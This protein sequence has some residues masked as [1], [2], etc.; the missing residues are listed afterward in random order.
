M[1]QKSYAATATNEPLGDAGQYNIATLVVQITGTFTGNLAVKGR[2][3]QGS[4]VAPSTALSNTDN[5][6]LG[7]TTPASATPSTTAPTGVGIYWYR[8]DGLLATADITIASGTAVINWA[9]I[10]G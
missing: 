9:I 3:T 6:A 4:S 8:I 5:V 10:N 2:I 7:Y 1:Q